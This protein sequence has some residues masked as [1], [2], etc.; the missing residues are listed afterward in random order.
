MKYI[1]N[2]IQIT[3][4]LDISV[5]DPDPFGP[6]SFWSAG[7]GWQKSAKIMENFHKNQPK[8]L[9]YHKFFFKTI[10]LVFT[11]INIS[12]INY[13]TDHISEKYIFL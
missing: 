6:V 12:P 1:Q 11:D 3:H 2:Q 7:S 13:K 4:T 10:K 9:E 5:A 8:L